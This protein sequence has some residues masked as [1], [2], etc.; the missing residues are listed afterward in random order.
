[1]VSLYNSGEWIENRLENLVG[2]YSKADMEIWCVNAN[3]PDPRDEEIPQKFDVRYVRLSERISVY[4]AWNHIIG[5]SSSLY[6]TNANSDDIVAPN[7][8]NKLMHVLDT[9]DCGFAY[10]SWF[11]TEVPN[12]R[13]GRL[14]EFDRAGQPGHF[15]GDIA[16]GGVG[17][18]PVWKRALHHNYGFFDTKFNAL[19]DVDWWTRCYYIGKTKFIWHE[20]FLALYLW[21]KGENLWHK[22]VNEDEWARY[23]RKFAEYQN[24]NPCTNIDW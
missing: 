22:A 19:A 9:H 18:F 5:N 11:C 23:H 20:E 15:K 3:S 13:W 14:K 7:C 1:M 21:R 6:I 2:S 17:H 24:G 10:C 4:A 16:K 12:Q 8:Y